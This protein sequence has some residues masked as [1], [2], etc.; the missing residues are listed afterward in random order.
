MLSGPGVN[1]FMF[2]N[3]KG[4]NDRLIY[5]GFVGRAKI[6]RRPLEHFVHRKCKFAYIL[7]GKIR[8]SFWNKK[9]A[10]K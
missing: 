7:P 2:F 1:L 3:G 4:S 8:Q 10:E 6:C 9:I 5:I